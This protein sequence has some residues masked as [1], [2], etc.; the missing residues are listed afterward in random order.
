MTPRWTCRADAAGW[1]LSYGDVV[2]ASSTSQKRT[3]GDAIARL[4]DA[5][6]DAN[7]DRD[8]AERVADL[9]T[10]WAAKI[11]GRTVA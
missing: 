5:L 2:I 10:A 8:E 4:V 11:E 3:V 6:D 9:L 1:S 7:A